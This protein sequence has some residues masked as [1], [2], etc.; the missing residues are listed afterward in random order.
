M[1][2]TLSLALSF[3]AVHSMNEP[4]FNMGGVGKTNQRRQKGREMLASEADFSC[5][6]HPTSAAVVDYELIRCLCSGSLS[7]LKELI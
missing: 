6:S 5:D 7:Q 2:A 4:D 1:G 3:I